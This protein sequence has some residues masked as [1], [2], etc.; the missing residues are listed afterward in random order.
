M[1][2][3]CLI[4][5]VNALKQRLVKYGIP[6]EKRGD[7]KGESQQIAHGDPELSGEIAVAGGGKDVHAF[8]CQRVQNIKKPDEKKPR[9]QNEETA[10]FQ[11]PACIEGQSENTPRDN[12]GE[13]FS[14]AVK[15]KIGMPRQ[16]AGR[17]EHSNRDDAQKQAFE[18]LWFGIF[19]RH[20]HLSF[21]KIQTGTK[22]K[23]FANAGEYTQS[24]RLSQPKKRCL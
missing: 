21:H 13:Q 10:G 16:Q 4:C 19:Q 14:E 7:Q 17:G 23:R 20:G 11:K 3:E 22:Q 12:N 24:R 2:Y 8:V 1:N 18:Y 5:Q 9:S 15:E 6:E